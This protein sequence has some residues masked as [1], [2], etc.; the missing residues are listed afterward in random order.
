MG[1]STRPVLLILPPR[2]KTL[3]P[4]DLPM[5]MAEYHSAP[6]LMIMAMLAMVSTL[7]MDV[8]LPH[9][10]AT[11]GNGGL[12]EGMPRL[13]SMEAIRAVS[14]P[15]TNAPAPRRI[16]RSKSKPE[17]KMSLPRKPSSSASAMAMRSLDTAMGYSARM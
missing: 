8:G 17:P 4:L 5:P 3:V 7:L 12:G 11:A 10:P 13:P 15:Q 14:S 1:I 6:F 16:S 2:A 9:T